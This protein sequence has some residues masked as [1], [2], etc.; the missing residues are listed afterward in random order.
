MFFAAEIVGLTGGFQQVRLVNDPEP[1]RKL[2]QRLLVDTGSFRALGVAVVRDDTLAGGTKVR[3]LTPYLASKPELRTPIYAGPAQGYAQWALACSCMLLGEGRRAVLYL[4]ARK[5]REPQ[6]EA[7]LRCGGE[8]RE[9]RPGYL[10]QLKYH[11]AAF[12][13]GGEGRQLLPLGLDTPELV[14]LLGYA[15]RRLLFPLYQLGERKLHVWCA[16][17]TGVLSRALQEALPEARHFAVAVGRKPNVGNAKLLL[18]SRPYGFAQPC[19]TPPP[20]PCVREFDAKAWE[21]MEEE[22]RPRGV[23]RLFWNVGGNARDWL[24]DDNISWS[25]SA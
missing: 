17:G 25:P 20:F 2:P 10:S 13:A 16:A 1:E 4:P 9:L 24:Q 22:P 19:R 5:R 8:L 18:P 11:A 21:R 7:A 12:E 14:E 15:L 6:S 3:V 23:L